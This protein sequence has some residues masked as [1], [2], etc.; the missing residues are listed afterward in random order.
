MRLIGFGI[1]LSLAD[2]TINGTY[3]PVAVLGYLILLL[4][5]R[6]KFGR[7][8]PAALRALCAA[9]ILFILLD[10][11]VLRRA[12][13]MWAAWGPVLRLALSLAILLLLNR[14]VGRLAD[15]GFTGRETRRLY[16][17]WLGVALCMA[18]SD[19]VTAA[20]AAGWLDRAPALLIALLWIVGIVFLIR[21][22]LFLGQANRTWLENRPAVP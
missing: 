1:I 4:E 6:E 11:A 2:I 17:N 10:F 7:P 18:S 16:R 8:G 20:A 9:G 5:S 12:E 14:R 19:L 15:G 3:I 21:D 13:P 22:L